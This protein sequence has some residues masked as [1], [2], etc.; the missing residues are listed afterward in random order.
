MPATIFKENL[1]SQEFKTSLLYHAL[2]AHNEEKV[3]RQ[4]GRLDRAYGAMRKM[5]EGPSKEEQTKAQLAQILPMILDPRLSEFNHTQANSLTSTTNANT[6][7][8]MNSSSVAS[9]PRRMSMLPIYNTSTATTTSSSNAHN[10]SNSLG[11]DFTKAVLGGRFDENAPKV[12]RR[13]SYDPRLA[14]RN[15]AGAGGGDSI[16]DAMRAAI[17]ATQQHDGVK[18]PPGSKPSQITSSPRARQF[19]KVGP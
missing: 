5:M 8:N 7:A 10:T 1:T 19:T 6:Y 18:A 11:V 14:H 13:A 9:T 17:L 2:D 3:Q 15:G 16:Q 12:T 4:H